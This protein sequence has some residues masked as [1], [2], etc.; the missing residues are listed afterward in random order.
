MT[1]PKCG[2]TGL[3]VESILGASR[4]IGVLV[5]ESIADIEGRIQYWASQR[6]DDYW[7]LPEDGGDEGVFRM[8]A[9]LK[10]GLHHLEEIEHCL[11][12]VKTTLEVEG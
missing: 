3:K 10:M 1:C 12:Y 4:D 9:G 11:K 7:K 2:T 6:P 8:L 5:R